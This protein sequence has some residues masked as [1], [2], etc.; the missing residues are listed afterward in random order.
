MLYHA[1]E[2]THAAMG[3]M[4]AA[5][6]ASSHA[7]RNPFYPFSSSL[8]A[9]TTAAA[10]EM[11]INATRRY[12]K[13]EFGITE[14]TVSG[15]IAPVTEEVVLDK[16]FCKLLHF[17]RSLTAKKAEEW[18]DRAAPSFGLAASRA[19]SSPVERPE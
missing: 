5:A 3:P 8:P 18:R 14:T 13:P 7:L 17:K 1:Y 10:C 16:P 9:R 15:K 12:A 19:P 6:Q 2:L 11:F 4:R